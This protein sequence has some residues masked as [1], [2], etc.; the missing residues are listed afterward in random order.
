DRSRQDALVVLFVIAAGEIDDQ[1]ARFDKEPPAV[2]VGRD[3]RAVSRQRKAERSMTATSASETLSS[4]AAT[5][6]SI[7]STVR[8]PVESRTLPASIGPP[9]TNTAG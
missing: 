3:H 9:D 2:G 6:A 4:A 5:I 8:A 7:R 1:M